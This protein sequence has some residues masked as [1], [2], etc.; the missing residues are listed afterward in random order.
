MDF[1]LMI[2]SAIRV[3]ILVFAVIAILKLG[4]GW[5]AKR[6][7]DSIDR[8]V[9]GAFSALMDVQALFGVVLLFG[10]GFTPRRIEHAV[11]MIAAIVVAHL[12]LRWKNAPDAVRLR[13][14]VFAVIVSLVLIVLGIG[15]VSGR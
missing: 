8:G 3:A 9:Q 11:T 1:V 13:N 12:P 2:H 15:R 14:S 5:L 10:S 4:Y 7:F 6:P